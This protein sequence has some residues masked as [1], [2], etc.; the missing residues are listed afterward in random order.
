MIKNISTKLLLLTLVIT[1]FITLVGCNKDST[2]LENPIAIV[3]K[4]NKPYLINEKNELLELSQYDS[5]VPYFDDILIVKKDNLFGYIKNTGE[6]LTEIIYT[7]AYPF[8]EGKAVVAIDNN[9]YIIN[10]NSETL[11][12][13]DEGVISYS[14]FSENKLV[15]SKDEKQ[16]YL[17]YDEASNSFNYLIEETT[18]EELSLIDTNLIYD[19][20][21]EFENGYAVVGHLNENNQLK[22]THIKD[23]GEKLY[24]YEWDYA[25][26]FSEGYAVVGNMTDYTIKVYCGNTNWFDDRASTKVEI[27]GYMYI[28]PEGKY[29]GTSS[30]NSE[31]GEEIIDPYV[32]AM[33]QDF[34]DNVA[35]VAR[36][37]FYTERK[38][39]RNPVYDFS[40]KRFFYNYDFINHEGNPIYGVN[41]YEIAGSYNNW[42][43]N[44]VMYDDFFIYEDFYISTF[45]KSCWYVYYTPINELTPTYPFKTAL[46]DLKS[47]KTVEDIEANFPWIVDYLKSFTNG[48]SNAQYAVE[49]VIT[50]YT[51]SSFKESKYLDNK[52]VAKAQTFSGMADSCGIITINIVDGIPQLSYIIPPLYE[53][54]IY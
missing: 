46:Y 51:L 39:N 31:T 29:L 20:C 22:Y 26:N 38:N 54:I 34:K 44:I 6:P 1:S 11:Y 18:S 41:G 53:E 48:K 42:G 50:P 33:A 37:F 12:T 35:L 19:Y 16:G 13:F 27:M 15:I 9:C 5:I 30:I 32:F 28:S 4:D 45:F 47:Y 36:L 21:S 25:N 14:Y 2:Y 10:Q 17:K 43:G 40:T 23:N 24:D 8:K 7:E 3:Y 52:L 49:K